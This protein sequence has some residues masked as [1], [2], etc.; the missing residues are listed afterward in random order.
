MGFFSWNCKG[1]GRS[2]RNRHA[3]AGLDSWMS[4]AVFLLKNGTR[5]LG[6]YDGYGR[7]DQLEFDDAGV[8]GGMSEWWHQACWEHA[9]KPDFSAPSGHASDQGYFT[10]PEVTLW[11]PGKKEYAFPGGPRAGL[12]FQ[13]KEESYAQDA[14]T[15][16]E[17]AV[18]GLKEIDWWDGPTTGFDDATMANAIASLK[19]QIEHGQQAY[20][21]RRKRFDEAKKEEE[22]NERINALAAST[23]STSG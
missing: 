19:E 15:L 14:L 7:L 11:P 22:E 20:E 3:N 23:D 9:G 8:D 4:K 18:D 2:I 17:A 1:C 21:E 6:E 16:I 5:V 12:V 13:T 10:G